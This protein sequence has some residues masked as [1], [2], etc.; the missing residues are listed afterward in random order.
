MANYYE[1]LDIPVSATNNE[2]KAAFRKLAKL[3]HPDK[4]PNGKEY[5]EKILM[6]YEVLINHSRRKQYDLKLKYAN[7]PTQQ[8]TAQ[9]KAA[10][11]KEWG[12]SEE[13]LKRRQYFKENYKKEYRQ[14]QEQYG[15][16]NTKVYN[17]YKYIL[18]AAPL[19]VGLF[20]FVVNGF[21]KENDAANAELKKAQV[22][23]IEKKD[24]NLGD[25]PYTTYFG[26]PVF[27]NDANKS[28]TIKN[29]SGNEAVVCFFGEGERFL[30]C[31]FLKDN[32]SAELSQL[33]NENVTVRISL[34]KD[35]NDQKTFE[36]NDA[37]GG[38]EKPFGYYSLKY[39]IKNFAYPI[40][41]DQTT[42]RN[43]NVITEKD[44]FKK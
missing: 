10:K 7:A 2:I 31:C 1:I 21:E 8:T 13:E 30:R 5:F 11:K 43:F 16:H 6:A 4:N 26:N 42:L 18:F 41:L 24:L 19:A 27:D 22:E 23:K 32:Y 14:Y 35:W 39:E 34:G 15:N 20:L 36:G 40:T 9:A 12:F 25:D 28:M 29:L 37:A 38:F 3:Y 17:E 44:F 33:P